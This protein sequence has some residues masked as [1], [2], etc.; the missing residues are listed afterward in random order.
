[1]LEKRSQEKDLD[2]VISVKHDFVIS[3]KHDSVIPVKQDSVIP[4]FG[5]VEKGV[6]P[7]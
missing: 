7:P 2:F 6:F 1:M 5:T 3:A 4:A